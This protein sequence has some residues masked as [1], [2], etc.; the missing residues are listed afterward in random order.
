MVKCSN[1]IASQLK[2]NSFLDAA[3]TLR[4]CPASWCLISWYFPRKTSGLCIMNALKWAKKKNKKIVGWRR[5]ERFYIYT[6]CKGRCE[7][8]I[9]F[10]FRWWLSTP[11]AVEKSYLGCS[12]TKLRR[13]DITKGTNLYI[14]EGKDPSIRGYILRRLLFLVCC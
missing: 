14:Y 12:S 6:V 1:T 4:T 3:S 8:N 9:S 2:I 10:Q 7:N 13:K 11:W 5:T